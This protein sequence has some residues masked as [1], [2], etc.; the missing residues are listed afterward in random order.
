MYKE[1]TLKPTSE[2]LIVV[3]KQVLHQ[4][5]EEINKFTVNFTTC[6]VA[7][8]KSVCI[9][10]LFIINTLLCFLLLLQTIHSHLHMP[11]FFKLIVVPYS[12]SQCGYEK[13]FKEHH[14]GAVI[15]DEGHLIKNEDS[16]RTKYFYEFERDLSFLLTGML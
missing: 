13:V 5:I 14:W 6:L 9:I 7:D 10:L 11:G 1:G 8:D 16:D 15:L 4:W 2:V 3:P 12:I